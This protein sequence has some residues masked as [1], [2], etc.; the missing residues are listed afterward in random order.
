M[1]YLSLHILASYL[2]PRVFNPWALFLEALGPEF[3]LTF[4]LKHW[5]GQ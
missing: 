4:K 1:T 5:G 2:L 3:T